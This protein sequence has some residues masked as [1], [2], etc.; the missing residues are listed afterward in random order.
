M[1]EASNVII[2]IAVGFAAIMVPFFFMGSE[3]PNTLLFNTP[4]GFPVIKNETGNDFFI[5]SLIPGEN[6]IITNTTNGLLI[7]A[8]ITING[9][10]DPHINLEGDAFVFKNQTNGTIFLRGLTAGGGVSITER[11]NDVLI[12]T[13][14]GATPGLQNI[15][16]PEGNVFNAT[17]DGLT[18][19]FVGQGI[20]IGNG[21]SVVFSINA[22]LGELN[23]VNTNDTSTGD[24]LILNETSGEWENEI[25]KELISLNDAFFNA[26]EATVD[27]ISG[28]D[29]VNSLTYNYFDNTDPNEYA[30]DVIEFCSDSDPDDNLTWLYVVP[31]DYT[32][33]DFKFRLLWSDDN[34]QSS[35]YMQV[36]SNDCEEG[37][38]TL[39]NG[40][41]TCTSSDIE[42][43]QE[44]PSDDNDISGFRYT[45]IPI[46][47]G[48]TITDARLQFHVDESSSGT[49][50]VIFHGED[51]DDSPVLTTADFDLSSRNKTSASVNWIVPSWPT[52]SEEG[53]DQLSPDLSSIIQEIVNRPGWVSGNDIS[54]FI[55]AWPDNSGERHAESAE[56]EPANAAE[57][58]ITWNTGAAG[59]FVCFEIS[60]MPLQNTET[61]DL[62]FSARETLCVNRS[63]L[64]QLSVTEFTIEETDHN[65][66]PEDLVFI[67]IHRPNDFT[68]GDYESDVYV[69]GGSLEWLQ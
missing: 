15:N 40:D 23:N 34:S 56:G 21:S 60:L 17:N 51:I 44:N 13:G 37:F 18:A 11:P 48:A 28:V 61:L 36:T 19:L 41:V 25:L 69:L 38:G 32:P 58:T 14:G 59:G 67:R 26:K 66:S 54:L 39:N 12:S 46:P 8:S 24:V 57:L 27:D 65:F 7:N 63:G 43:H 42:L 9:T 52:V 47:N 35:A 16:T 31:K 64:D 20:A 30:R 5:N 3:L 68:P 4:G 22:T 45:S 29:C 6:I 1:V 10:A 49:L 55:D 50:E 53:A 62:T 2:L 33:T